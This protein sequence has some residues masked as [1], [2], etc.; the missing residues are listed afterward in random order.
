MVDLICG[1]QT[2]NSDLQDVYHS[3]YEATKYKV[4]SKHS[5]ARCLPVL[6]GGTTVLER[7]TC[8]F[9][10]ALKFIKYWTKSCW[11]VSAVFL[12]RH[13]KSPLTSYFGRQSKTFFL[14]KVRCETHEKIKYVVQDVVTTALCRWEWDVCTVGGS[15]ARRSFW[16]CIVNVVPN[17][18]L[19]KQR[20]H[21]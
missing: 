20:T 9:C 18:R 10:E 19:Y 17:L 14:W 4:N 15:K 6:C 13:W 3:M 12:F 7:N 1:E 2:Q 8:K 5:Q 11:I 16:R 21:R